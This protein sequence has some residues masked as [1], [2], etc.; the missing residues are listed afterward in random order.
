MYE[1]IKNILKTREHVLVKDK[2]GD[3]MVI[4]AL[5]SINGYFRC[6]Y[7]QHT[8]KEAKRR[9]GETHINNLNTIVEIIEVFDIPLERF[10]IG[11]IV[12]I[13][14]NAKEECEKKGIEWKDEMKEMVGKIYEIIKAEG[15]SDYKV[16][17]GEEGDGWYFPHSALSYPFP[18][19]QE[20]KVVT[21]QEIAN[22]FGVDIK[23]LKIKE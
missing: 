22:K 20:D 19:P 23:N 14:P 8:I 21:K 13:L 1:I 16:R 7:W 4:S 5:K 12:L 17:N 15:C 11:D 6:S 3:Y 10:K 2:D 9:I 18:Q